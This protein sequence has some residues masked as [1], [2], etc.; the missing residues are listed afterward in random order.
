MKTILILGLVLCSSALLLAQ[1]S[2]EPSAPPVEQEPHHHTVLKNDSVL[3]MHMT[4]PEGERT[5]YHTHSYDRLAIILTGG[6]ITQQKPNEPESGPNAVKPGDLLVSTMGAEPF[7][8]RVHNAGTGLLELIDIELL[9]RPQQPSS[10]AAAPVAAENPS[11]RM[12]KW[13]LAPGASS[14]M[15]THE[16]PYLIVAVGKMTLKMSSPDGQSSS[17][18]V[19]S[20]DFHWLDT[21]VT[22]SLTNAGTGEGQIIEVELK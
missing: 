17:H 1:K 10:T 22:H 13:V 6:P 3:V 5:F 9:K 21:K 12:Y 8:H 2:S 16:R 7:V 14:P 15:H 4:L 18:E 11:A 19:Q 20:G